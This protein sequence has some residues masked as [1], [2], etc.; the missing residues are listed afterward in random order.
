MKLLRLALLPLLAVA[1]CLASACSSDVQNRI[2]YMHVRVPFF[3]AGDW[4]LYGVSGAMQHKMFIKPGTKP[5]GY[6]YTALSETG[7]GGV[8]LV[9]NTI[10][11][12]VAYDLACPVECQRTV[13]IFVN[14]DTNLG[15]C[16]K[17]GSTFNIY[18]NGQAMSGEAAEK[19]WPLQRYRVL[20]PGDGG[21]FAV[22]RN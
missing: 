22:I 5:E 18:Y 14:N 9:S 3:S 7:F 10:G 8:L 21:E 1:F 16:P 6:F 15:Q 13:R 2:P 11:E 17:C 20:M 19:R 4:E 12:P